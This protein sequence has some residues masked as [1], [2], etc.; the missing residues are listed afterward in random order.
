MEGAKGS[1]VFS[2]G[3]QWRS[4]RA[5]VIKEPH[6]SPWWSCPWT[7]EECVQHSWKWEAPHSSTPEHPGVGFLCTS[8]H[9]GDAKYSASNPSS[10]PLSSSPNLH[11]HIF[12][13]ELQIRWR[14]SQK[15][16]EGWAFSLL[17]RCLH[18]MLEYLDSMPS[19]GS[20]L[21][22]PASLPVTP[23]LGGSG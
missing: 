11:L 2:H 17:L 12:P 10:S 16:T 4:A 9:F 19:S 18:F 21:L 23:S 3:Q 1:G 14:L 7:V 15:T 22:A 5:P 13:C 6:P 20:W 8:A